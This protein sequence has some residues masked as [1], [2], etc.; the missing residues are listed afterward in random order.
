[1]RVPLPGLEVGVSSWPVNAFASGDAPSAHGSITAVSLQHSRP[2]G[3][4]G[5]RL[6]SDPISRGTQ[7]TAIPDGPVLAKA[8]TC[9][10]CAPVAPSGT[11]SPR[12]NVSA[13]AWRTA[14]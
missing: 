6:G 11:Y 13:S 3:G 5:H 8:N 2:S 10:A 9:S 12:P 7:V 4:D 1:M 14:S